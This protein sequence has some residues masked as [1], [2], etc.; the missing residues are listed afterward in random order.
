MPRC[1]P[2]PEISRCF[3]WK[4]RRWGRSSSV[5]TQRPLSV[6]VVQP[7]NGDWLGHGEIASAPDG[8]LITPA[9]PASEPGRINDWAAKLLR[10]P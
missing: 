7:R 2:P 9:F 1:A 4:T 6:D 3:I 10:A 8:T 5:Y